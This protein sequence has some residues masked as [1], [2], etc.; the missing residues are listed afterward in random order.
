MAFWLTFFMWI[1]SFLLTDYFRAKLPSQEP[2]GEG[3][4]QSPTSTEGR[5][6]PQVV[7]GTVKVKGP[8]TLWRGE[9]EAVPVTVETGIVF[10][11]D[12][13]VGFE[14]S[15]ALAL[16]QFIGRCEGMTAI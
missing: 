11:K 5:K 3:D 9:W 6:V 4:F 15:I 12:E 14:Y 2:S 1:A 8:N 7:A 13:T 16:G 10:K